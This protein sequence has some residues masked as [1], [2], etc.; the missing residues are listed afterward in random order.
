MSKPKVII[1]TLEDSP[2]WLDQQ[3]V[4]AYLATQYWV[5][6]PDEKGVFL[7]IG[8][9][10]PALMPY[11][12]QHNLD[13]CAIITAWNPRSEILPKSENH[14]R[15][16]QLHQ[17]LAGCTPLLLPARNISSDGTW[18]AEAGFFAG[19]LAAQDAIRLGIKYGQNAIVWW[20]KGREIALWWLI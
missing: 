15:H 4:L 12:L 3:L 20:E 5:G 17:D 2:L 8:G 6:W 19:G 18:P 11:L 14:L 7:S 16:I 13:H 1:R 9:Q 10:H